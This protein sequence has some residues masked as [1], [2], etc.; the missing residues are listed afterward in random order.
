[1]EEHAIGLLMHTK[2]P[3]WPVK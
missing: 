2:V 3:R 1:M